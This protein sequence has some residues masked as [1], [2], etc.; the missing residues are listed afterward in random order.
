MSNNCRDESHMNNQ[1]A[2]WS[3]KR[4]TSSIDSGLHTTETFGPLRPQPATS[5]P[6]LPSYKLLPQAKLSH[7]S[8][9]PTPPEQLLV[10]SSHKLD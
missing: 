10:D 5:C 2:R 7:Q 3:Y 9:T 6:A 1:L 4:K 8:Q